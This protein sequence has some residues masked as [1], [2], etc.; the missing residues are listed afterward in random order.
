MRKFPLA[1]LIVV[2]A[3]SILGACGSSSDEERQAALTTPKGQVQPPQNPPKRSKDKK[4]P[5]QPQ[6]L[7]RRSQGKSIGTT[8]R[9]GEWQYWQLDSEWYY[10]ALTTDSDDNGNPDDAYFDLDNDGYWDT[11]LYNTLY[12]DALLEVV[13]YDMDENVEVE[14]RLVDGDQRVGFDYLYADRD[15]NGY[16]DRWRQKARQIIPRS[17]IDAVTHINRNNASRNIMHAFYMQTG[18]SLLYPSVSMPY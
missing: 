11:N 4:P 14:F 5:E 13:D 17:N 12:S 9:A 7:V 18:K 6:S 10:D 3:T 2:V 16:W 15:Q 8:Q 1:A